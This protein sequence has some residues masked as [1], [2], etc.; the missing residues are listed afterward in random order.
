MAGGSRHQAPTPHLHCHDKPPKQPCSFGTAFHLRSNVAPDSHRLSVL[1]PSSTSATEI[2]L[3]LQCANSSRAT[4]SR[5]SRKTCPAQWN[6]VPRSLSGATP[7]PVIEQV[8]DI[9]APAMNWTSVIR[10]C[11]HCD[12]RRTVEQEAFKKT[13]CKT[14]LN[15]TTPHQMPGTKV[16]R[17]CMEV[18]HTTLECHSLLETRWECP[19]PGHPQLHF[20][21]KHLRP[22]HHKK[23]LQ[24]T[25]TATGFSHMLLSDVDL[26]NPDLQLHC[27]CLPTTTIRARNH[28]H[29][30]RR[31]GMRAI[32]PSGLRADLGLLHV[33]RRPGW[34]TSPPT[35]VDFWEL[36][37]A[38]PSLLFSSHESHLHVQMSFERRSRSAS[39]F[40][41]G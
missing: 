11:I 2:S 12:S 40:A 31:I 27:R 4:H 5:S 18:R 28:A 6:A 20:R 3:S 16:V 17:V 10:F 30:Q 22:I 25:A 26:A 41:T 1:R 7:N 37:A 8:S 33:Q 15:S 21:E 29:Q 32:G 23:K 36:R 24:L 39:S 19:V 34:K 14:N 38:P 13:W 9:C 35:P